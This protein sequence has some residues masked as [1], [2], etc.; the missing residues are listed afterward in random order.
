MADGK[1]VWILGAG[2]SRSLGAPL[3]QDLFTAEAS[4]RVAEHYGLNA[5]KD[6][7]EGPAWVARVCTAGIRNRGVENH[8]E[9]AEDFLE[10]LELAENDKVARKIL[11]GFMGLAGSPEDTLAQRSIADHCCDFENFKRFRADALQFLVAEVCCFLERPDLEL[12]KWQPYLRWANELVKP[13]DSVLTFNYDWVPELLIESQGKDPK[14]EIKDPNTT[15]YND[16]IANVYKLHGSANWIDA[17]DTIEVGP[18]GSAGAVSLAQ[19]GKLL[20]AT[21]GRSKHGLTESGK[22]SKLWEGAAFRIAQADAIV[23]LGYRIPPS[24]AKSRSWLAERIRECEVYRKEGLDNHSKQGWTRFHTVL[25]SDLRHHDS[26]RLAG[27]IPS[28]F[29][30]TKT[31]LA[32]SQRLEQWPMGAEDFLSVVNRADLFS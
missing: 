1:I 16:R 29:L 22:L 8:W 20:I 15:S 24:D 5:N 17:D 13:W 12:E 4:K 32:R 18:L 21:P 31:A 10:R 9:H 28:L 11:A 19:Q 2:F 30:V 27:L 14:L 7:R 6:K 25:G 3:L 23:F 26:V